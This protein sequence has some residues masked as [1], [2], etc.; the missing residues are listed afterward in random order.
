M[1]LRNFWD[2]HRYAILLVVF[3]LI[4]TILLITI[5]FWKTLLLFVIVGVCLLIG[6]LLDRGGVAEVKR[7]FTEPFRKKG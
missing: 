2:D 5:G 7:F 6:I 4:L 3:G 1:N